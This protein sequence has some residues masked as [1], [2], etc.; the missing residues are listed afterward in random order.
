[1]GGK[2]AGKVHWIDFVL[3][4]CA[5]YAVAVSTTGCHDSH[6][7]GPSAGSKTN[8]LRCAS[9]DECDEAQ[10]CLCGTC[11][12]SCESNTECEDLDPGAICHATDEG[13]VERLCGEAP[14]EEHIC[15]L[16]C[17]DDVDCEDQATDMSCVDAVCMSD[18]LYRSLADAP[19]APMPS[20][21]GGMD[22]SFRGGSDSSLGGGPDS[23]TGGGADS[24]MDAGEPRPPE[25]GRDA[26]VDA[27][28]APGTLGGPCRA[29]DL[30]EDGSVGVDCDGELVCGASDLCEPACDEQGR[31][32]ID[33]LPRGGTTTSP[34]RA[35]TNMIDDGDS[36]YVSYGIT[37][38]ALFNPNHDGA[39]WKAK[40]GEPPE[41]LVAGLS[42]GPPLL[43]VDDEFLYFEEQ[44]TLRRVAKD[45]GSSE[46]MFS[47]TEEGYPSSVGPAVALVDG[48]FYGYDSANIE[49][50]RAPATPGASF[51]PFHTLDTSICPSP[52]P[53]DPNP[54]D[55]Q[56][57][58]AVTS[59][60]GVL[61]IQVPDHVISWDLREP[62]SE[63]MCEI[64]LVWGSS[65]YVQVDEQFF[66]WTDE[67]MELIRR[68]P[69]GG[70]GP[71]NL[72]SVEGSPYFSIHLLGNWLYWYNADT[73]PH[74]IYRAPVEPGPSQEVLTLQ[75]SLH[76]S[77]PWTLLP[78]AVVWV[79]E[80]LVY[81]SE[82][83]V[84]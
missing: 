74:A 33:G 36:I 63:P 71:F 79:Y 18:A 16:P 82:E 6:E 28:P 75:D 62:G 48:A 31:C 23:S 13:V 21:D 12:K 8:W 11:T 27:P 34:G 32:L 37:W 47:I 60:H 64:D 53:D 17:M 80:G 68:I 25:G 40:P 49:V 20:T 19:D 38:D 73:E 66:Y 35:I 24:S 58:L 70:G 69:R 26:S 61:F 72:A 76:H 77:G 59:N 29:V 22:S 4:L 43:A 67:D 51:E 9:D 84:Q 57:R 10:S 1:M 45:G 44:E 15:V 65:L 39:I 2:H 81:Y 83:A 78:T 7:N 30:D 14:G 55:P 5:A 46:E 42:Q 3:S 54:F 50:L 41:R 56:A 52:E